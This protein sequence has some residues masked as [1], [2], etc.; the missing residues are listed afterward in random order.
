MSIV[1]TDESPMPFGIHKDKKMENVPAEYLLFLYENNKCGKNNGL[2]EYIEDNL[3]VIKLEVQ[4][5][6]RK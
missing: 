1:L 6:N 3:D 4:Q 2:Q 5:K